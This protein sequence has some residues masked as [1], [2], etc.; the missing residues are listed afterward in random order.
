MTRRGPSRQ[1]FPAAFPNLLVNGGTGIAV[2]MATNIPPHNLGEVI[3][4]I[5]AQIDDPDIDVD[6]LMKHVK[7][8]D[9]P[10]GCA[11]CGVAGVRQYIET[12]RGSMKV[13]GKAGVEELKGNREQIVV[14]E[15]P[16]NVN[17]ATLV[18]K[19]AALVNDKVL[20]DITAIR[21]ESDENTRVVIELKRDAIPKVVI[22][23]LYKH[24]AMESS[25]AVNMLAIDHGKPK[26]LSLKEA[27]QAFIEHRR[28]V[29][30]RRTR[31]ELR[32]AE[33]RAETLEGY[34]IALANLDEFIRIIRGSANREE[35]RVKLL[36]FEFTRRQVEQIGVLIRNEA[37]LTEGRYAFSEHQ[38]NQILDLRLYQLTGLERE[39]IVNEYKELIETIKDLRDILAKEIR[40][41]QI[42]KKELREI[43]QK[44][45]GPRLTQLVPDEGEINMED[46]IANEGTIISITHGGFIKR[47]AVSAFRAQRR[48]GK[49]VI[50]MTTREGA[51]QEDEGDFIEH[52]F[53]A[54]THDYLMFF[55]ASGRCYVEKV[56]EIPEMG[57]ASKGRS[58]ANLLELRTGEKIAATIRIQAKRSG[59]GP[60]VV[61]E[62]WDENLHI[63][64]A[65]RS[66]IVKKSNLSDYSNVR[67]GGI[68]AINIEEDDCLIDAVLT[69]GDN[70]IV[71][72]TSDGMSLR[73][74]EDQL[75]DQGRN[76]V[77]VWGI[78]P[79]KNDHI[80]GIAL[81]NNAAM[82]L[83]A[84]ENGIGK[85]TAFDNYRTQKRGGKGI[86]TMKTGDKTGRVVGALTVTEKDELMLITTKGQMVRTRVSEIRAVGR[87]TMGVKLMDLRGS[88]KLQA[89]APV[90]SQETE[91]AEV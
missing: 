63:V 45:A 16:Y 80:V 10:T 19:I 68:I 27:N 81:V 33:E 49:G 36:A 76:T 79:T 78:R 38:T 84:G 18:E 71:L 62:T 46:L 85:R 51:T 48:G 39:K 24:T 53:T 44:H 60:N 25:F 14:T 40:V 47:T 83:V 5:C 12:G 42:I 75:R 69:N 87:N 70:E 59:T 23:N 91:E 65:T 54:T 3:D 22:N 50:G 88:E 86:I 29:V 17:R 13:R 74:H 9:F 89:I 41:F 56:Y 7:G 37:R 73:F 11:I 28:E 35:A 66:G 64:F 90:V 20:T 15:I 26:L 72:I 34:L 55:T 61:D 57:R 32:K 58:I 43:Q 77:G 82:L 2:G 1:F 21:D 8:P 52:L 30:L 31:F 67:K 4:G 6:G